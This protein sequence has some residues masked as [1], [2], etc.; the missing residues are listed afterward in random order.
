MAWWEARRIPYNLIV[1]LGGA[2]GLL[3]YVW[4]N[5]LPPRLAEPGVDPLSVILF[6]VGANFFYTAGWTAELMVRPLWPERARILGPQLLILGTL[7][8]LMLAFFPAL[9][10]LIWWAWRA[11]S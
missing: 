1:G 7:L 11:I 9:A 3:L 6:G 8:S 4:F 10:S 2:L 5:K